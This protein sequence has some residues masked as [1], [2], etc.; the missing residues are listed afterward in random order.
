MM[1]ARKVICP[2]HI[3][4]R[5]F[6]VERATERAIRRDSCARGLLGCCA[7]FINWARACT[8]ETIGHAETPTIMA[9][10]KTSAT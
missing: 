8:M 2:H 3:V 7:Y 5:S 10:N 1:H 9:K 4:K 6:S